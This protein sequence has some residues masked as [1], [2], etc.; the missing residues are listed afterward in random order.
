[1][2]NANL[3]QKISDI[4]GSNYSSADDIVSWAYAHDSS[5]ED[6]LNPV[7]PDMVVRPK[8]TKEVQEI[9]KL[10]NDSK[11]PVYVKGGG[12]AGS[13]PRG[14][15]ID[16]SILLDMTR[17]NDVVEISEKDLTVTAQ[18]GT[19]WGKLN[20]EV[21]EEGWRL[22]YKGTFS[23]YGATIGGAI[24]F[25]S[26]GYASAGYGVAADEITNLKVVLPNGEILKTGTAV[27]PTANNYYRYAIGPDMAGPF[28][29]SLGAFGA[30]TEVSTKIYPRAESTDYGAYGFKDY[31]TAQK[32]YYEWLKSRQLEDVAWYFEDGI[33]TMTPELAEEG[34]VSL[35][36]YVVEDI[37]EDLVKARKNVL[38]EKAEEIG[39]DS[40]DKEYARAGWEY[41]F[42]LLPR[43]AGKIGMFQW[44]CH[45]A[46]AGD[47]ITDLRNI[48]SY[49]NKREEEMEEKDV[50]TATVSIAEDNAGHVSTSVYFNESRKDSI[51]LAEEIT[52]D[53]IEMAAE[54]GAVN[55]K[56]GK[57][58]YPHTI[59]KNPVYREMLINFKKAVDPNNIMNPGALTIP[60][61]WEE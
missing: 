11:K 22:G 36:T 24:A 55:Y 9:L 50:H 8:T 56:P 1:M 13:W 57:L 23:G 47:C 5:L 17:M 52:Y 43:W 59:E 60:A 30:I 7:P 16:E 31:E 40:L 6:D 33:E 14:E 3:K 41:K 10:A 44:C 27:A 12:T 61:D 26:N 28:I 25:Q 39:G 58:W 48:M 53:L 51:E 46:P 29:G 32:C 42:E 54:V 38:D 35:L 37:S 19:T 15:K 20:A 34:Y 45:L 4:V 18:S 49:T 2:T 21:E